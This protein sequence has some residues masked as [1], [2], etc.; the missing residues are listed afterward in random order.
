MIKALVR[1]LL[2]ALLLASPVYADDLSNGSWSTTDASNS[3]AP[4]NGWPAGM[5]PNQVE[6]A[7]RADKGGVKRWWERANPALSTT[8][9]AGAYV[10][11]PSNA[12]YPTGYTQGEVLC[13][14]A[15]FTAV[16]S[17]T[18]NYNSLGAK[19]I[20]VSNGTAIAAISASQIL[21]GEQFCVGYDGSLNSGAGGFQL[22]TAFYPS[23]TGY[24]TVS[25]NLSD[26]GSASTARTNLGLGSA[27]T[28][29][30]SAFDAAGA[31]ATAQS[32]AETYAASQA[33]TAQ[34]NAETYTNGLPNGSR[35]TINVSTSGP[36]GGGNAGDLWIQY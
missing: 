3:A 1:G 31:A 5:F 16:G 13:A 7:A 10:I 27:A 36:S 33:S 12:S 11:T 14:K 35:T 15:N 20:Y 25:N 26:L 21:T 24:L 23:L 22:L 6:P 28:S 8:G 29:N 9:S 17:D 19:G 18:L 32:N 2:A 4:P 34:S 30:T